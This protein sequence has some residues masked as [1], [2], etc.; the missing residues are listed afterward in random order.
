MVR[1]AEKRE[2]IIDS[3]VTGIFSAVV[4][5]DGFSKLRGDIG[6]ARD[7]SLLHMMSRFGRYEPDFDQAGG[8]FND[9]SNGGLTLPGNSSIGFPMAGFS[10]QI[11]SYAV[12]DRSLHFSFA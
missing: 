8:T 2:G 11:G 9:D 5:G 12:L 1:W 7:K 6:K 3:L 4:I 10:T